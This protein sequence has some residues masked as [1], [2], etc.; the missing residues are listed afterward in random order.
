[1]LRA[2]SYCNHVY[3][4]IAEKAGVSDGICPA[5]YPAIRASFGFE[6]KPYPYP[7]VVEG[8]ADGADT[9]EV[10]GDSASP[11]APLSTMEAA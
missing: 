2:C 5:C 1:M 3:G 7:D 8:R 11:P 9:S 6:P 10:G 4:L